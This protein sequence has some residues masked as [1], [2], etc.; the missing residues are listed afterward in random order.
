MADEHKVSNIFVADF[1]RLVRID[2]V[3]VLLGI[4]KSTIYKYMRLGT[5]P[6]PI[7]LTYRTSAWRLS[8]INAW[9]KQREK[10]KNN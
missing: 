1:D 2:E 7:K 9:V 5:F 3:A 8:V 4:A 10:Y 6:I